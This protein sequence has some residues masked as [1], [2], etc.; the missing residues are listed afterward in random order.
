MFHADYVSPSS[1]EELLTTLHHHAGEAKIIAG[2]TDLVPQM[3]LGRITPR[4]LVDPKRLPSVGISETSLYI[5]LSANV[6]HTQAVNS[7][8][9]Q[10]EYPALVDACHQVGGPPIRNRG[11]LAGNLAN[12]SPA[13]DSALPLLI[14]DAQVVTASLTGERVIPLAEFYIAPGQAC[15]AADEFIYELRLPKLPLRTLSIFVKLGNR[16]AMA[17][18]VA[19]VAV[20]LSLDERGRITDAR[21]ALGSVA[22]T[23]VRATQAEAILQAN[24]MDDEV[25]STTAHAAQQA[26]SPISDLRASA[27]YR[28]KMVAVLTRRALQMVYSQLTA[29]ESHA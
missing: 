22:P 25:I 28:S 2:G 3:R 16:K 26:A 7:P 29:G 12:A 27:G 10:A 8:L 5:R 21:I 11:T 17:I 24:S 19:S 20:R 6:T 13:A 1:L 15:L 18:A 14:Y 4:I 23:P 9:L